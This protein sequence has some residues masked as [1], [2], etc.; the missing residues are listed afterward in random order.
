MAKVVSD[1]KAQARERI[2]RCGFEVFSKKGYRKTTMEAIA[3]EVGVSKADLYLYYDN[4]TDI[5]R[6]IQK[7][8]QRELREHL[9][10]F[11]PGRDW[12]ERFLAL[13]DGLAFT[14]VTPGSWAP[15]FDLLSEGMSDPKVGEVLRVD[16]RED[17]KILA[18]LVGRMTTEGDRKPSP[19]ELE[20]LS[21]IF[22][23][24]I[25]GALTQVALGVPW[26]EARRALRR[27]L[28][29]SLEVRARAPSAAR[30]PPA[31]E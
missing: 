7:G 29:A 31:S 18:E 20:E 17:R 8:S 12:I 28:E 30:P 25:F 21:L 5:L 10:R 22:S 9:A 16:N 3:R 23:M 26:P 14:P 24:L 6:E 2:A 1:Y 13:L 4:K 15:W 11:A 27:S 19:K